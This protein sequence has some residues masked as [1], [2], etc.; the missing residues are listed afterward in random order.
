MSKYTPTALLQAEHTGVEIISQFEVLL[1]NA[2]R[3]RCQIVINYHK[4]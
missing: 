1:S 3:R 4:A 2:M